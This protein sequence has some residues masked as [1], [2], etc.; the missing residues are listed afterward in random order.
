[1]VTITGFILMKVSG[2]G[3]HG[4]NNFIRLLSCVL[5]AP[6]EML[7]QTRCR[8]EGLKGNSFEKKGSQPSSRSS[9]PDRNPKQ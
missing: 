9:S 5:L 7:R 3:N 2:R 6:E 1:M 4:M 8:K